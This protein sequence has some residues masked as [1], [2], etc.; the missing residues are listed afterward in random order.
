[1]PLG[2]SQVLCHPR[3]VVLGNVWGMGYGVW[4]MRPSLKEKSYAPAVPNALVHGRPRVQ[5]PSRD[6]CK[7]SNVSAMLDWQ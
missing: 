5:W 6:W 1:M 7:P 3:T 4:G 2:P